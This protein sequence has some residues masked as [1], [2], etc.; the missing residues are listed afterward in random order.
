MHHHLDV[1]RAVGI[2]GIVLDLKLA[3][4]LK[5]QFILGKFDAYKGQRCLKAFIARVRLGTSNHGCRVTR[6]L[7]GEVG[8]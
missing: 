8:K 1:T 2:V 4:G 3:A 5:L 7:H 6:D